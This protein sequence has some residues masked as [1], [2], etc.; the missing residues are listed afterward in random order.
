M[1][2]KLLVVGASGH[3]RDVVSVARSLGYSDIALA[4]SDGSGGF[5]GMEVMV[6]DEALDGVWVDWDMVVAVGDN[7]TRCALMRALEG[8][9]LV[10]LVAPSAVVGD[11]VEMGRGCFVGAHA[12][13]G[14][15]SV[16]GNGVLI[17]VGAVVGHDCDVGSFCQV[18]PRAVVLGNVGLGERVFLGAG[19]VVNQGA[20]EKRVVLAKG[21]SVG[22]GCLVMES[23]EEEGVR[24]LPRPNVIFMSE[25]LKR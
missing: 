21:V 23:V 22:M 13:V 25:E 5:D 17:N 12:Y 4:T 9:S 19:S 11:G 16:L 2:K 24:L 1:T 8:A 10:N 15:G 7:E 18:A 3:A 14:P 20:P 6:L